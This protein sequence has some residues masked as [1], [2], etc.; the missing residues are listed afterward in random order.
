MSRCGTRRCRAVQLIS[1]YISGRRKGSSPLSPAH[2]TATA[3]PR[4]SP[5][6]GG[7]RRAAGDAP[8]LARCHPLGHGTLGRA[9]SQRRRRGP[10]RGCRRPAHGSPLLLPPSR[11]WLRRCP[12]RQTQDGWRRRRLARANPG[13]GLRL[14]EPRRPHLPLR[15]DRRRRSAAPAPSPALPPSPARPAPRLGVLRGQCQVP[16]PAAA[17][18]V[19]EPTAPRGCTPGAIHGPAGEPGS[20]GGRP[21]ALAGTLTENENNP[22]PEMSKFSVKS[23]LGPST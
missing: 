17:A 9:I 21:T 19:A 20:R 5:A 10:S 13:R 6:G 22:M 18:H 14:T 8:R 1:D 16:R 23:N 3:S 4:L 12:C 11:A 15:A 2:L 7:A